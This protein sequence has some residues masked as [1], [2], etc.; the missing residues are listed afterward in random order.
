MKIPEYLSARSCDLNSLAKYVPAYD[1]TILAQ[2]ERFGSDPLVLA[3][4]TAHRL[5]WIGTNIGAKLFSLELVAT[6]LLDIYL[7]HDRTSIE[8][9]HFEEHRRWLKGIVVEID[10]LFS[11]REITDECHS[12][13]V[14]YCVLSLT[15]EKRD[16]QRLERGL[17]TRYRPKIW[18]SYS[19]MKRLLRKYSSSDVR[20]VASRL[21]LVCFD[22]AKITDHLGQTFSCDDRF[23]IL[24]KAAEHGIAKGVPIGELREYW[25][26]AATK[27]GYT[28][29]PLSGNGLFTSLPFAEKEF[30]SMLEQCAPKELRIEY[31]WVA[32]AHMKDM[33]SVSDEV[34]QW[35]LDQA[36]KTMEAKREKGADSSIYPRVMVCPDGKN[37]RYVFRPR[38]EDPKESAKYWATY[39]YTTILRDAIFTNFEESPWEHITSELRPIFHNRVSSDDGDYQMVRAL[40]RP[41]LIDE[42]TKCLERNHPVKP[43]RRTTS[44][45]PI[46]EDISTLL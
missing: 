19:R 23:E 17:K 12:A 32:E 16:I 24:L 5:F 6:L 29:E 39:T 45:A 27:A 26:E 20:L 37:W 14:T 10:K 40:V 2:Q 44:R 11:S 4:E 1:A 43:R 15:H 7:H 31:K 9:S 34:H 30:R 42:V 25:R 35:G 13:I 36:R 33:V 21:A 41:E 46:T 28:F 3:A 18:Q 8:T 22:A 38:S